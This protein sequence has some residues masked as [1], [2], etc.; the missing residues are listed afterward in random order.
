MLLN[1]TKSGGKA[2]FS[3]IH[4][5]KSPLDCGIKDYVT[6]TPT[7]EHLFNELKEHNCARV[8]IIRDLLSTHLKMD[9]CDDDDTKDRMPEYTPAYLLSETEDVSI[10]N[11]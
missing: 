6:M 11:I 3:Q 2:V 5:E 10:S 1:H 9:M 4:L 8:E 7:E